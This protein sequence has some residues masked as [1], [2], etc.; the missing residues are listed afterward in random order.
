MLPVFH[1][2]AYHYGGDGDTSQ[3]SAF[4]GEADESGTEGHP[5]N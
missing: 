2:R 3:G 4:R 1:D 5:A